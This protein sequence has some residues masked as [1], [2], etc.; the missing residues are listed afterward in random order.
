MDLTEK[1]IMGMKFELSGEIVE[2]FKK[3]IW[4][5][6]GAKTPAVSIPREYLGE[7]DEVQM[8]VIKK[9]NGSYAIVIQ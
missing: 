5:S 2:M 1:S 3:R 7:R 9:D 8:I 6:G 4:R